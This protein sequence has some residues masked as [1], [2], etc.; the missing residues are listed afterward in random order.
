M[1]FMLN[2][3]VKISSIFDIARETKELSLDAT[4]CC[5]F[6]SLAF[7]SFSSNPLEESSE[8]SAEKIDD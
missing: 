3:F 6:E 2:I 4:S 7:N 8:S 1:Y 5:I